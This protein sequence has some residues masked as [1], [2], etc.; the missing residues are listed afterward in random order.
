MSAIADLRARMLRE[1]DE[2][3][4]AEQRQ[5]GVRKCGAASGRDSHRC[6]VHA[7]FV[8]FVEHLEE[9]GWSRNKIASVF[10]V[11]PVTLKDW[12]EQGDRA[13]NQLPGWAISAISRFPR[14]AWAVFTDALFAAR[15][16]L[17]ERSGTDG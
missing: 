11:H 9:R 12:I 1:L 2:A 6:T 3:V 15:E 14:E 13:R 5:T 8:L 7:A 10:D 17:S 4:A 16:P